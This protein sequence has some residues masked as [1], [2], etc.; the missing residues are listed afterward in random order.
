MIF[1]TVLPPMSL[2]SVVS[3]SVVLVTPSSPTKP[4]SLNAGSSAVSESVGSVVPYGAH[5][6]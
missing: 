2:T 5:H 4:P 6:R 1:M 3:V